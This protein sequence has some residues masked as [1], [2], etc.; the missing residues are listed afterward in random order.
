MNTRMNRSRAAAFVA[1]LAL[2][3]AA[4]LAF[5]QDPDLKPLMP[6]QAPKAGEPGGPKSPTAPANSQ[7]TPATPAQPPVAPT[8]AVVPAKPAAPAVAPVPQPAIAGALPEALKLDNNKFDW[9]DISDTEPVEHAFTFTNVSD[10]EITLAVA[11]SCGCTVPTMEKTTYKPGENGKVTARF[12]PHGRQGP[13]NKTLTF[14]I[15]QPQ[16][17]FAQQIATLTA[18]VKALVI[19]D[20]PK[21][22]LSEVDHNGGQKTTLKISGRKEGFKVEQATANNDYIKTK[23]GEPTIVDIN[24]EKL[25]QVPVEIEI[26]KGAPIGTLQAQLDIKTN[27]ERAHLTPYF[28]GADVVGDVKPQPAQAIIRPNDPGVEFSTQIRFDSRSGPPFEILSLESDARPNMHVVLDKQKNEDNSWMVTISGVTPAEP[29]MAQ[30]F[31]T[32]TTDAKGGETL[33]VPFTA[34]IRRPMPANGIQSPPVIP[35][36]VAPNHA[37]EPVTPKK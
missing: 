28:L 3:A 12:D 33:K 14:T 11:A 15:T 5:Q 24:G 21:M 31:L 8:P 29:G 26:G 17:V 4:A 22:F 7:Q 18:N 37:A 16:G 13:Q 20:P 9:G 10:K 30:S 32:V 27:D 23:L 6:V 34:V 25:T 35:T 1:A 19:F 36:P 2:P